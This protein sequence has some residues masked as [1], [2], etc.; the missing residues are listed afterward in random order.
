MRHCLFVLLCTCGL[1]A[2]ADNNTPAAEATE[3]T[4]PEEETV[5]EAVTVHPVYHGSL[6]LTQGERTIY[7]DPYGGAERYASFPAPDLVLITHTHPD[8]L[9]P[10]TL[11]AFDLSGATLLAPAAVIEADSI[12]QAFAERHTL[13]N[14]ETYNWRDVTIEAIP[15]YNP[16]PKENF[17]P[18]G[19]FN[20][21]VVDFG[22]DNQRFYISGDTEGVPAMRELQDIDVAFVAMNL[23]YT[24]DVD[25]AAESVLAFAPR[26]VY[27][28]HYRNQDGSKSD[29]DAF[30]KQVTAG[31]PEIQVQLGNWYP[32]VE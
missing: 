20:G 24:M 14:G 3:A 6:V 1:A 10:A 25:Q 23:P 32:D 2:C 19:K 5:S 22:D 13:A 8:H 11:G 4:T 31:N 16:P 30:R 17:H 12:V 9:D 27:P 21:Y 28:Y 26:E 7:I 15:A 18:E 29:V